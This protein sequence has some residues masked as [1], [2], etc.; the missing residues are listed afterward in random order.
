MFK[1]LF[2]A[3]LLLLSAFA[4]AQTPLPTT[5]PGTAQPPVEQWLR[6]A[7]L[8]PEAL[9]IFVQPVAADTPWIS[10]NS[11]AAQNPASL[12]KL[13][14]TFAALELL[15]PA[16]TWNTQ[17]FT[18]GTQTGSALTGDVVIKGNGDPT[19]RLQD[20]W[21]LLRQLRL[22]GIRDIRG[23]FIIDRSA[24]AATQT[25][26]AAFDGEG[27]RCYN[28]GPDAF[29]IGAKC[30]VFAFRHDALTN[31]WRVTADPKPLGLQVQADIAA[32]DAP[33][34]DWRSSLTIRFG[35]EARPPKAVFE[36]SIP[37]ACGPQELPRTFL[38]N[39]QFTAAVLRQLWEEQGGRHF[40]R[41]REGVLPGGAARLLAQMQSPPL[42]Q[43]VR[44][45]NKGSLNLAARGLYLTLGVAGAPSG[46][47]SA[48]PAPSP[49]KS[50]AAINQW[51]AGRGWAM[52][53]LV[54]ENG[55]GLSR[56]ERISAVNL[57]AM[58]VGAY[59]SVVMPEFIG[60]LPVAGVDGTMRRR[61]KSSPV[62][63]LAHI[64]TGFLRDARGIAGYVL[65]ASGRRYAV[66]SMI[67]GEPPLDAQSIHDQ[68]LL[69]I[70]QNG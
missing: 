44:E 34:T 31:Q 52:P 67:N 42:A 40:G 17:V 58:L 63:G 37:V 22:Q 15:G 12:M 13:L 50:R 5:A 47:G 53:E 54:I 8:A 19:L 9:S 56:I 3:A 48:V 6:A 45:I 60:S 26:P 7:N 43:V 65:A 16:F 46:N 29:V 68:L 33:C 20:A 64:K 28:A 41:V 2:C 25:D 49:D 11:Q 69:W 35:P 10:I 66:V 36:G 61:L 38:T 51:L 18:Q 23:D 1:H 32:T 70:Q 55:S 14:T 57:G 4:G 62:Y 21:L 24:F 30:V 59:N 27:Q 39:A